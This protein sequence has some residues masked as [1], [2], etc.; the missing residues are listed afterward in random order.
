MPNLATPIA[1]L[2]RALAAGCAA[3]VLALVVFG[4][5]PT[6]HNWVHASESS[7][8]CAKHEKATT[9]P[10]AGDH[11]CAIVM[12]AHGVES[13]AGQAAVLFVALQGERIACRA[14]AE[15]HLASPRYLR[16]P[17]RGPPTCRVS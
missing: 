6:A 1:M 2:H 12:F 10:A 7:H 5:S 13:V 16:Q 8:S 11:D 3:L 14:P 17:E 15:L 9:P 4:A